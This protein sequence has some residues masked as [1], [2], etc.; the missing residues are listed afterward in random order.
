MKIVVLDGYSLNPGDLSWDALNQLGDVALYDRTPYADIAPRCV[1]AEIVLTNKTPLD[2]ATLNQLPNLKYIGVLATGYNIIDTVVCEQ[3]GIV[4]SNVPGY[5]TG[6]VAQF[7]FALLLEL[8]LHVQKHSDAVFDGKWT[9]SVDFS[10][11]DYP[12]IELAGKTLG[13]IGFGT[14]GQ[15]VAD[16]A[17]AFDMNVI[18]TGRRQTGQSQRKSFKWVNLDELLQQADVIS[19]HCP[20][21]PE[22]QGLINTG[23]LQKM[24]SSAFLINTSRGPIVNDADLADALNNKVIAGAGI[25][26]LSK[27]PPTDGNPLFSAKNCII[28]PHIAWAAK[29]A[30]ARLMDTVISNLKAFIA[31]QPVNVVNK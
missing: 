23:N 16:I 24:K 17:M 6:A 26:V 12:L 10:F 14:I 2:E 9:R 22:T 25:D 27:E 31:G 13:I 18:A 19:I 4:V 28:T 29:E 3:K 11:W 8:C 7:V 15:K 20:L 5:G 21:T 30:R 1:G